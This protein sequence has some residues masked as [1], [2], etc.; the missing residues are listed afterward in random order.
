M[1]RFVA[2]SPVDVIR[3]AEGE[4]LN[5]ALRAVVATPDASATLFDLLTGP[6]SLPSAAKQATFTALMQLGSAFSV[7]AILDLAAKQDEALDLDLYSAARTMPLQALMNRI[8]CSSSDQVRAVADAGLASVS[9]LVR[10]C[11][12]S[13][14]PHAMQSV[15]L[16]E[17]V[18]CLALETAGEL[19][20]KDLLAMVVLAHELCAATV[21]MRGRAVGAH[22]PEREVPS[23]PAMNASDEIDGPT[24]GTRS[25]GC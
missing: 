5:R 9:D 17:Q 22:A 1:S 18:G 23:A 21:S 15:D 4:M 7:H 2:S 11:S 14:G 12:L 20:R 24:P 25:V 10:Y 16:T 6:E 3:R 13:N 8:G 19:S